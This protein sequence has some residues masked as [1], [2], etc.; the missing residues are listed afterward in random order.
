MFMLLYFLL[1]LG[2]STTDAEFFPAS[3]RW[4]FTLL[5]LKANEFT[6]GGWKVEV[7][8]ERNQKFRIQL[9][10]P[11]DIYLQGPHWRKQALEEMRQLHKGIIPIIKDYAPED[12]LQLFEPKFDIIWIVYLGETPYGILKDGK[13]HWKRGIH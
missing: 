10:V 8:P 9:H 2:V 4:M 12:Y 3:K 7:K 11:R 5:N 13:L 6:R 1:Q